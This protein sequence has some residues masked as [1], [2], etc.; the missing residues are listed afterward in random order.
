MPFIHYS[1]IGAK[2]NEIHSIDEFLH[3]MQYASLHYYE[4]KSF[5]FDME[6]KKYLLPEDFHKFTLEEWI[7]YTGA[8]YNP[9]DW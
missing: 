8:T 2:E 9:A 6:Y 3:I 5:G 1:G 4:M 7:D